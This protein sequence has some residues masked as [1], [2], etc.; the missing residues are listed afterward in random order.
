MFDNIGKK[1]KGLATIICW[2]GIVASIF[3]GFG[4]WVAFSNG[5]GGL[6][7]FL[8]IAGVGSLFS[9]I[10]SFVLYGFGELIDKVANIESASNPDYTVKNGAE[11]SKQYITNK[12]EIS[13]KYLGKCDMC[14]KADTMVCD[15]KIVD[16]L[17]TRYR[18]VCDDCFNKYNCQ[19]K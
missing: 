6:L 11:N 5:P 14:D 17:G 2:I 12:N 15:V 19:P 8:V 4:V 16:N 1:I 10:G 9:W 3:G 13:H 18:K 7:F